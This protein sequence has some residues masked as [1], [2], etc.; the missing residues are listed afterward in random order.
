MRLN[1]V[2]SQFTLQGMHEVLKCHLYFGLNTAFFGL[3]FFVEI[4]TN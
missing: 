3:K 1:S 4:L 2:S